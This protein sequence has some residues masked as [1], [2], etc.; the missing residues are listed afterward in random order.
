MDKNQKIKC[1]VASCTFNNYEKNLCELNEIKVCAC[2]NCNT[3]KAEDESMC[4]SYEP[5]MKYKN[6]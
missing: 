2:S 3:G 1:D 6:D 4:G 5:S